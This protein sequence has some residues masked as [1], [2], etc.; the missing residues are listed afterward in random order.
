VQTGVFPE[1]KSTSFSTDGYTFAS[2]E[3]LLLEIDVPV[4]GALGWDGAFS[5]SNIIIPGITTGGATNTPTNTPSVTPTPSPTPDNSPTSTNTP[6]G[7]SETYWFYDD[8]TPSQYMMYT[9]QPNGSKVSS[10]SK[11]DF[12]STGFDSGQQLNA[13]TATVYLYGLG[14]FGNCDV[15][16][17]LKAG[18]TTVGSGTI[19]IP[20]SG[21]IASTSFSVD[22]YSF[23]ADEKLT[24][25]T[26]NL[27][28]GASIAWDGTRNDSRLVVPGISS[29]GAT[30]TPTATS[31]DT[32]TPS[33]TNTPT[34]TATNTAT[35]TQT[36]TP[37]SEV[38]A[39]DI[40]FPNT[41]LNGS[42]LI[43]YDTDSS[44]WQVSSTYLSGTSWSVNINA[45]D[46]SADAHSITV[47]NFEVRLLDSNITIVEGS[48][49]PISQITSYTPLSLTD[50][51][52]LGYSGS[53]GQGVFNF[54]PD[55][56]LN[57]A[58]ETYAGTYTSTVEV[59][60]VVG[61]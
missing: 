34:P 25:S 48:D 11:V 27:C 49:K 32:P 6:S 39:Q 40:T 18:S 37:Y 29:G 44:A 16:L 9:S 20:Q 2:D 57:V 51:Q 21:G 4:L 59:T 19:T 8:T 35:P 55:F 28:F 41:I 36:P 61:P 5:T 54:T 23:A 26:G 22:S 47:G 10:T 38:S 15:S 42:D 50:Q 33:A 24:L 52:L 13:G 12:Y 60:F 1:R 17:T 58:A 14:G 46:F 53:D 3:R 31:T 30:D 56:A 45:T 7:T 43:L